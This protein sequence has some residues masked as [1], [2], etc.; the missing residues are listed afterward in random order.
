MDF[1]DQVCPKEVIPV[2]NGKSE[3]HHR[4]LLIRISLG[5]NSALTDNFD[6]CCVFFFLTKFAQKGN[7]RSKTEKLRSWLLLTILTF[8]HG[9]RQT[10]RYI[11]VSS[12]SSRRDKKRSYSLCS[13][14][15]K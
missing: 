6:L 8:P 3:H 1:L 5:T 4:I 13:N 12:P 2:K 11:N 15:M 14:S 10:Q 9:G 7:F